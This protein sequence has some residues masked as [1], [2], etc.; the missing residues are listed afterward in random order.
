MRIGFVGL[1]KL[2]LPVALAVNCKDHDVYGYDINEEQIKDILEK[3]KL[4]YLEQGAN[5]LLE[6]HDIQ[7]TSLQNVVSKSEIIFVPIQTPHDASFEGITRIPETRQDFDYT[8]LIDGIKAISK[9]A[10]DYNIKRT[11]VII[12]TVLPGTIESKIKPILSKNLQLCYNP[13]FIAMGTTIDDFLNPEFV[14]LGVDDED[15]KEKVKSFYQT[16]HNKPIYETSVKNAELIKVSYNTYIG[17]KIVFANTIMEICH[18]IGADV[19]AVMGAIKMANKRLI[20]PMYLTG[21]MGDGGGCHP[22]DNIAMSWLAG[23]LNLSHNFFEDIMRAREEQTEFL[24]DL[25]LEHPGPYYV[26]GKTFKENTNLTTGS[27]AILLAN[28]LKERGVDFKHFDPY[29]IDSPYDFFGPG[30]YIVVTKHERFKDFGFP[31]APGVLT[32]VIDVWGYLKEHIELN[33][34]IKYIPVGR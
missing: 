11:I 23:E 7:F 33:D 8:Y 13:F 12:S 34:K 15:A 28:I 3:R 29:V 4:P 10:D 18:K 26:L 6:Y 17:M 27:P 16:I 1:G 9:V 20:S 25:L 2:G 24:A 31:Y 14:L 30:T 21:G 5:D 19:D 22:R 32:T